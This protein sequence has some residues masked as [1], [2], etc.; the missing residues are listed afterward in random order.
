M[1]TFWALLLAFFAW[2]LFIVYE[3]YDK[4]QRI[5]NEESYLQSS[6]VE[7]ARL[8]RRHDIDVT[9][10]VVRQEARLALREGD[11]CSMLKILR[12]APSLIENPS[13]SLPCL[14]LVHIAACAGNF[15]AVVLLLAAGSGSTQSRSTRKSLPIHYAVLSENVDI[16]EFLVR[17]DRSTLDAVDSRGNTPMHVAALRN[18]PRMIELLYGLGSRSLRAK[19]ANGITPIK[20]AYGAGSTQAMKKLLQ[21][22]HNNGYFELNSGTSTQEIECALFLM[23]LGIIDQRLLASEHGIEWIESLSGEEQS[24]HDTLQSRFDVYF[25]G[26]LTSR[27]L[28]EDTRLNNLLLND[29]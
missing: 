29:D 26:S 7:E 27:L 9:P 12:E 19:T 2:F 4:F 24:E 23:R 10:L 17:L 6:R 21:L 13:Y 8:Q 20:F 25:S 5:H 15:C 11:F 14:D 1:D 28:L 18:N 3:K 22:D 16:V